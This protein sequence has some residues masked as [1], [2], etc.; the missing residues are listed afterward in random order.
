[1]CRFRQINYS[2]NYS[3]T[4]IINH[5]KIECCI[6]EVMTLYKSYQ[7]FNNNNI[8]YRQLNAVNLLIKDTSVMYTT[9]YVK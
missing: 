1:M 8:F 2:Y 7:L 6:T 4:N 5:T 3:N 9:K